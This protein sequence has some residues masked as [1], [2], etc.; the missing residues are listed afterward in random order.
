MTDEK[1]PFETLTDLPSNTPYDPHHNGLSAQNP[2][3]ETYGET[4][5]G[6]KSRHVQL[7]AL[8][9]CIGTGLFVGT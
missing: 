7:I 6:L 8:G 1:H 2:I 9:G 5:R 4:H 3:E